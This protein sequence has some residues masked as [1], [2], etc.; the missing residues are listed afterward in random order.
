MSFL[1][2]PDPL[3]PPETEHK[4]NNEQN[5]RAPA[6]EAASTVDFEFDLLPSGDDGTSTTVPSLSVENDSIE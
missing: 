1:F 6:S 2:R 4:D 3:L 5:P